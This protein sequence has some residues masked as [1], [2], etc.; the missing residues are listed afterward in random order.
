MKVA[1]VIDSLQWGGAQKLLLTFSAEAR[2][3]AIA[4]TVIT[5]NT[6]LENPA[7]PQR[8]RASGAEV[9][10][11]PAPRLFDL[12]RFVQLV[13]LLRRERFD[14]LQVHLTYANILAPLAAW[15]A[16][17]PVVATL[18]LAGPDPGLAPRKQQL[19]DWI[20]RRLRL[21]QQLVAVGFVA[22]EFYAPRLNG[23]T[24]AVIPNAVDPIPPLDAAACQALRATLMD[25][26]AHPLALAVGRLTAIKAFPDLIDAWALVAAT[27]PE[28]RLVIAG[29][30]D[31][32]QAIR[33]RI[34][35]HGLQEKVRLLGSRDDVPQLLQAA[36]L[37]VSSSHL[38]GLPVAVLEALA[39]GLPVVGTEVGD[40]PHVLIKDTGIVVPPRQPAQLAEA[41]VAL[42]D[43]PARR[44]AMSVAARQH[45]AAHYSPAAWVDRLL[46][47]YAAAQGS[48]R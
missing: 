42:L 3:R 48:R 27:H 12:R 46:E 17:T 38:E 14:V 11:L 41:I 47:V 15:F 6:S 7:V 13:R 23:R 8:L 44:Q 35:R 40:V 21:V 19:E 43:D 34:T 39:A 26:P 33:A 22:A 20:L 25:D 9:V 2:R 31:Q 24:I 10:R 36:D 45:I 1:H 5:L 28:A 18:H 37:F 4:T 16:R 29:S 32:E 30:G